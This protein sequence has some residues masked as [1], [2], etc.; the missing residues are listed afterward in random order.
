MP[1]NVSVVPRIS[2][3]APS[4]DSVAVHE[5]VEHDTLFE[6]NEQPASGTSAAAPASTPAAIRAA[7]AFGVEGMPAS[8]GRNAQP[9]GDAGVPP[10]GE[11]VSSAWS[12]EPSSARGTTVRWMVTSVSPRPPRVISS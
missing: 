1:P 7:R 6:V 3:S 12:P 11:S 4:P 10:A 8:L 2:A 5:L 9:V